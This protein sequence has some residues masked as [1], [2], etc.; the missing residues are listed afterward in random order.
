MTSRCCATC[1]EFDRDPEPCESPCRSQVMFTVRAGVKRQPEATDVCIQHLTTRED[2][3]ED[4]I[5]HDAM[6]RG[7]AGLATMTADAVVE[8]RLAMRRAAFGW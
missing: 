3:D 2:A 7:G 8:A 4:T 5:I 1:A 6:E